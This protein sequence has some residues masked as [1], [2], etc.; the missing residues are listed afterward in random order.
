MTDNVAVAPPPKPIRPKEDFENLNDVTNFM[1]KDANT[2]FT[3]IYKHMYFI[4]ER[5][6]G[7]FSNIPTTSVLYSSFSPMQSLGGGNSDLYEYKLKEN[8]LKSEGSFL[9]IDSYGTTTSDYSTKEIKIFI[10]GIERISYE[11]GDT[12]I[13]SNWHINIKLIKS[14]DESQVIMYEF[15]QNGVIL[16]DFVFRN[17]NLDLKKEHTIKFVASNKYAKGVIQIGMIV[18]LFNLKKRLIYGS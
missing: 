5:T 18:K 2:Y 12:D 9:E 13:D 7:L 4:W 1:K 8:I 11:I 15:R 3:E 6:G 16:N 17:L 10:D 14:S